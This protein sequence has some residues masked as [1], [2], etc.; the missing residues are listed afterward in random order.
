VADDD[1]LRLVLAL[2]REGASAESVFYR[3]LATW[4]AL[5][6]AFNNNEPRRDAFVRDTLAHMPPPAGT[7]DDGF[8]RADYLRDS[9]RN[10]VAHAVRNPPKPVLNPDDVAEQESL[11]HGSDAVG[12]VLPRQ[13]KRRWPK[14]IIT[15][16]E[17]NPQ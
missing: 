3:F 15:S 8:D 12:I 5:D 10:A 2:H 14:G 7:H 9:L 17:R 11:N 13:V 1:R 6:A 4:N 16:F